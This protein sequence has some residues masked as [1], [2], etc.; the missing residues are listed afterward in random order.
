[1]CG[2]K[3]RLETHHIIRYADSVHLRTE[4]S[5]LITLCKKCHY[6]ITGKE[7]HY[8]EHFKEIVKRNENLRGH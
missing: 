3:K 5:N 2:S 8:A 1:M 6:N 4:I 7:K